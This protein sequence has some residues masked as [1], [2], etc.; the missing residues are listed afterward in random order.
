MARLGFHHG[1]MSVA[2]IEAAARWYVEVLDFRV[3]R[4]FAI[5]GGTK[6]MFLERDGLRIELF[7]VADPQPMSPARLD[8][9]KDLQTLGNKHVAFT[10]DDYEGFR[11]NLVARGVEIVL[12][13]GERFGRG[14][15][16]R[17]GAD[18]VLEFLESD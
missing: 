11:A 8:P 2:D 16:I 5:P 10:V 7:Q 12:E 3:E 4:R 1:A 17:D 9:R 18:N 14:L 13:V 6:A 15:F